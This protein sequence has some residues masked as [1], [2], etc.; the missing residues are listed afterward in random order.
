MMEGADRSAHSEIDMKGFQVE[1]PAELRNEVARW[2]GRG[3][4]SESEWVVEAV[5]E[6]L[7]SS[8]ELEDLEA[9]AARGSREA[10]EQMLAKVPATEPVPRDER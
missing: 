3:R 10:F 8:A 7:A 9:R 6:K 1:L 4:S 5:R 2:A